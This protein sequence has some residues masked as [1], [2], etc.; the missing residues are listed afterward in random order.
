MI[1]GNIAT[2]AAA[3]DLVAAGADA[4]KVGSGPGSICTTRIVAGIGVPQIT[5]ISD[6]AAALQG[7]G[8]PLIADGGI[9]FSGDIS[10]AVAA[11]ASAVSYTHLTLPPNR[12][13]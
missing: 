10:K 9:R 6:V 2:A 8:V 3:K 13:V 12:E 11:G 7:T 5:A 1:G 4:V